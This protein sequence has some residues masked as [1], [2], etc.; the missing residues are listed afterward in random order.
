LFSKI[1]QSAVDPFGVVT[2][3]KCPDESSR[4]SG[5][6]DPHVSSAQEQRFRKL[7]PRP[8]SIGLGTSPGRRILFLVRSTSGSATGMAESRA[9][10]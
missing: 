2:G 6:T 3:T 10:V 7:H 1:V 4:R 9:L 8:R 5:F